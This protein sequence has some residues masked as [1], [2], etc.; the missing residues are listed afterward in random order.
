VDA[1]PPV[2]EP[3]VSALPGQQCLVSEKYS[4]TCSSG[5]ARH[6]GLGGGYLAI[7]RLLNHHSEEMAYRR[8]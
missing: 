3:Q 4:G 1:G 2:T 7:C 6:L 8:V 5:S